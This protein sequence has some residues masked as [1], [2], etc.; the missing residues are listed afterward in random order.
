MANPDEVVT[1]KVRCTRMVRMVMGVNEIRDGVGDAFGL[2][3][4]VHRPAEIVAYCRR[5]VEEGDPLTGGEKS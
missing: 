2:G 1:E 3:G 5:S 4:F